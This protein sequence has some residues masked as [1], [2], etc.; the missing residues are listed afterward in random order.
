MNPA[1]LLLSK[2]ATRVGPSGLW[3]FCECMLRVLQKHAS[4]LLW[5]SVSRPEAELHGIVTH[6]ESLLNLSL[7]VSRPL[8]NWLG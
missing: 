6:V 8:S 3:K 2:A 7:R 5:R 4:A 1:G